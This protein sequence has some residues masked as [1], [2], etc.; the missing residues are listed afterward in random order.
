LEITHEGG[1]KP[2]QTAFNPFPLTPSSS[3][4]QTSI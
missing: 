4:S 3:C 2:F 1:D